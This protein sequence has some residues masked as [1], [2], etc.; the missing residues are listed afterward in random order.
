MQH[1]GEVLKENKHNV[2]YNSFS[3]KNIY[4]KYNA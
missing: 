2:E 4:T 1:P 3:C